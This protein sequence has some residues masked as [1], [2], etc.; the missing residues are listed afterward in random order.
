[1]NL[2]S[3]SALDFFDGDFIGVP[4]PKFCP[5]CGVDSSNFSEAFIGDKRRGICKNC[6]TV[7]YHNPAAS[8]SVMVTTGNKIA[9]GKIRKKHSNGSTHHFAEKWSFVNG[10]LEVDENYVTGAVRKTREELSLDIEVSGVL[11]VLTSWMSPM[12]NIL[13]VIVFSKVISGELEKT[14]EFLEVKWIS[15]IKEIPDMAFESERVLATK[16][17]E[18]TLE[19]LPISQ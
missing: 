4:D 7:F 19:I 3:N 18:G 16:F 10:M 9:M 14:E 17:F 1:M 5:E 11:R 12:K 6:E 15:S 13:T 2:N 8:I